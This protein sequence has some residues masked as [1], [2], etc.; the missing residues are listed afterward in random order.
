MSY[1]L[2]EPYLV[3]NSQKLDELTS[4]TKIAKRGFVICSFSNKNVFEFFNK[5]LKSYGKNS[6][7]LIIEK[8]F[9]GSEHDLIEYLEF[10]S[11]TFTSNILAKLQVS[12]TNEKLVF[13]I[14][15][16]E[17]NMEEIALGRLNIL[18]DY[19]LNFENFVIIWIPESILSEFKLKTPDFWRIRTK[20]FQFDDSDILNVK[21]M[22]HYLQSSLRTAENTFHNAIIRNPNNIEAI[23][24]L[25]M[26]QIKK[27]QYENA[28]KTFNDALLL[29][30]LNVSVLN[31]LGISY[32]YLKTH[33]RAIPY[34]EKALSYEP[35]NP[36]ILNN[37][38]IAFTKIFQ[39]SK[40]LKYF[41]K[42]ISLVPENTI[43]LNNL[44]GI[45]LTLGK[46]KD[47]IKYLNFVL[48]KDPNN[49]NALIN[50]SLALIRLNKLDEAS[51]KINHILQK[52]PSNE[53][54]LEH[55]KIIQHKKEKQKNQNKK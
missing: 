54:A 10:E 31:N 42:A 53:T 6:N 41:K 34:F 28:I 17:N 43:L 24:N 14:S 29:E 40:S 33:K 32:G 25:G 44:G 5:K 48:E 55:L 9:D 2:L 22:N 35:D 47:A 37:L 20:I 12:I 18:R 8:I 51:E 49:F 26:L 16:M 45:Y 30:P 38:G 19:F 21:G 13:S 15:G 27:N 7:I 39:H 46:F 3:S 36:E 4:L 1:S 11:K 50:Y 52:H 23:N